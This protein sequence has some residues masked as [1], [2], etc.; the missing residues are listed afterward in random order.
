MKTFT[1]LVRV[2]DSSGHL[3]STLAESHPVPPGPR[4]RLAPPRTRGTVCSELTPRQC[5]R[6]CG[7]W[8][9][10]RKS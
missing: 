7:T 8:N 9:V 10:K 6:G 5:H 2:S 4:G 1:P 3:D